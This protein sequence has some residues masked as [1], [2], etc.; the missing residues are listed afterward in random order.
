MLLPTPPGRGPGLIRYS[1]CVLYYNCSF[2]WPSSKRD[3]ELQEA[4][5]SRSNTQERIRDGW[6]CYSEAKQGYEIEG[7]LGGGDRDMKEVVVIQW[8]GKTLL[9]RQYWN[10]AWMM[11]S[12]SC[13]D[14]GK[15]ISGRGNRE[16]GTSMAFGRLKKSQG[17]CCTAN[18]GKCW[19]MS[20][21]VG[22]CHSTETLKAPARTMDVIPVAMGSSWWV[23]S[24]GVMWLDLC[25]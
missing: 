12:P 10:Q 16:A 22:R 9:R 15:S 11:R 5:K 21:R 8:Q 6:K 3:Q 14:R 19:D 7:V 1:P 20:Q 24:R 13:L 2:N 18:E 4:T 25:F 23:L 17:D